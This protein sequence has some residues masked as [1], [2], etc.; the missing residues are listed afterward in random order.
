MMEMVKR[1]FLLI[2]VVFFLANGKGFAQKKWS[3]DDCI[4]YAM[5]N[6]LDIESQK[7]TTEKQKE[8]F[9]QSKRDRLPYVNGNT[10]YGA[11]FGKSVDPNDNTV[12]YNNYSSNN[13]SI[14]TGIT[15]FE[16]FIRNNRIAY[17]RFIYLAGIENE[18]SMKVEIGFKV[19]DEFHNTL[20][21]KGLLEIVKEQKALT[22]LNLKKI[23][24]EVEVGLSA[25]TDL[26]EIEARMA[27]EE[28]V[29]IRTENNYKASLLK[30]K[31]SMN[32]PITQGLELEELEDSG[33]IRYPV[34]ENT[35]SV[36]QM[37][38]Q[39]LP[40]VKAKIQLLYA[41]EK[42]L[43][44]SKG[45]LLPSISLNG[46]YG[47]GYSNYKDKDGNIVAFK[48]QIKNN[49][50]KS[51]GVNM[52]IPI[53]NRWYARS[54]IKQRKLDLEKEKVDLDNYKNQLYYEIE[55][56]CQDLSAVSAE[57]LQAKKQSESN[58]LAFE[59]AQKKKDQGMFNI[60]DLYTSKNLLSNAQSELL[61]TKLL[62]LLKRK[63]LDFYLGKEI[64]QTETNN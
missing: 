15:L 39:H 18:R 33:L 10:N 9:N 35:D 24:K 34:Y 49:V 11:S 38:L 17:N 37:A 63:T 55:S 26:L 40:A 14:N 22:E 30:L 62:Y 46:S 27:D 59:V 7:I 32:Y 42:E 48:D 52:S 13:Y 60:I 41:V 6:N 21:Y 31:R 61:R 51:I 4:S 53:F 57:Y 16:G 50:S 8:R 28:L 56:Y 1:I 45:G 43:A 12:T 58:K 47:T 20:Y 25:K 54:E 36:Y 5:Q 19:M 2:L 3:L 29:V 23:Q 64:F 44:I